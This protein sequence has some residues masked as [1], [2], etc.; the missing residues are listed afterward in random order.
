MN[1]I[2]VSSRKMDIAWF[3]R[4]IRKD[5]TGMKAFHPNFPSNRKFIGWNIFIMLVNHRNFS[6]LRCVGAIF[7]KILCPFREWYKIFMGTDARV[8]AV[9]INRWSDRKYS[10]RILPPQPIINS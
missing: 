5:V 9:C 4:K 3:L 6:E 1:A 8:K 10:K 7:W 2:K